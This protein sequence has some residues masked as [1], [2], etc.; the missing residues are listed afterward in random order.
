[1][2]GFALLLSLLVARVAEKTGF[3]GLLL[4]QRWRYLDCHKSTF[5]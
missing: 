3:H 1:M 5:Q 4:K 2:S